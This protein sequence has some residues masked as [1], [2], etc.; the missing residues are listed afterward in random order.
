VIFGQLFVNARDAARD[1]SRKLVDSVLSMGGTRLDLLRH[2]IVPA[3]LPAL[4]SSLRVALGTSIAILFLSETF[5]AESG[6]G[7]FIVDSWSRVDYPDMY[8]AII[9]LSAFSLLLFG[10]LDL[11]ERRVCRWRDSD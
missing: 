2:V 5:A 9:A 10:L 6:L 3:A 11:L 8:A 4:I 1:V 7:W